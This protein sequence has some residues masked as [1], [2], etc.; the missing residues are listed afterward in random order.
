MHLVFLLV[1]TFTEIRISL[2][3]G[4]RSLFAKLLHHAE[5]YHLSSN[6]SLVSSAVSLVLLTIYYYKAWAR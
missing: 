5:R 2:I 6:T 1:V 3:Q 4:F